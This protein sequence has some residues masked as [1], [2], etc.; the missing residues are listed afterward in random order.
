MKLSRNPPSV[1]TS[2]QPCFDTG[3]STR[4]LSTGVTVGG[5]GSSLVQTT[6]AAAQRV[7]L[8]EVAVTT[9]TLISPVHNFG[10]VP[11]LFRLPVGSLASDEEY[12]HQF[13]SDC[14][15]WSQ[16]SSKGYWLNRITG[17]TELL[18]T[19]SRAIGTE[20]YRL[21]S[22]AGSGVLPTRSAAGPECCWLQKSAVPIL[23][24]KELAS[25][26][27]L[28]ASSPV[29]ENYWLQRITGSGVLPVPE[30]VAGWCWLANHQGQLLHKHLRDNGEVTRLNLEH[31]S[32]G[33]GDLPRD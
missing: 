10:P 23:T 8:P 30:C 6:G 7:H 27:V 25:N 15:L 16:K 5:T 4:G 11:V 28:T 29:T 3:T 1:V 33:L 26:P 20:N 17:Y 24:G 13:C 19:H 31:Q 18:L 21:P 22:I 2:D 9:E 32:T 12:R 14:Q